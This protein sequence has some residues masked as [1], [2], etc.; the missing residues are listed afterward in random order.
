MNEPTTRDAVARPARR[1]LRVGLRGLIGAVLL[2]GLF[3]GWIA[4]VERKGRER[5][6]IVNELAGVGVRVNSH[7][8]T[9]LCLLTMKVLSTDN[10]D[11][12][13]RLRGWVAPWWLNRPVGFNAGRLKEGRVP[14]V[15]QPLSRLGTVIEVHF[16]GG[17]LNGLR[18]FYIGKVPYGRL[19]P[20]RETCTFTVHPSSGW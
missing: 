17:S 3:F 4:R 15:V 11:A 2:L 14:H 18:L 10:I 8:P 5:A 13:A 12:E 6:A 16:H 19:G 20:A 7:E 9:C 1:R